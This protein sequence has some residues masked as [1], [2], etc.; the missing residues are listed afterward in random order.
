MK[1]AIF[2]LD[3]TLLA[4]DSDY[5]WGNFLAAKG[6]V[7]PEQH[8]RDNDR[9]Y[10]QYQQNKLDIY[11]YQ[12]FVLTPLMNLDSQQLNELHNE[13]MTSHINPLLQTKANA[14]IQQH[15][16]QGDTLLVITATNHFIA[17]PIVNLLGIPHLLATTPEV[18]DGHFT[19]NIIG[20]PCFQDG[21]IRRLER[22]LQEQ[23][24]TSPAHSY[25]STTF[26]SDS[27]NDAPLL[28][29][30]DKAI[31]VDPDEALAKLANSRS[32]PIISL[33]D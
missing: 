13:F 20:D 7:N 3:N 10:E 11:E 2:D 24:A 25:D 27:M 4:G 31:A 23:K 28:K 12:R 30:V 33:R 29:Y 8:R 17:S 16:A 21:K 26:Y 19:G 1:L 15:Q 22:W 5:E 18:I 6:I 14:L 32:W 9:F